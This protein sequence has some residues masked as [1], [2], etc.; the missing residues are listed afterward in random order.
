VSAT[1]A[2]L[3]QGSPALGYALFLAMVGTMAVA[4]LLGASVPLALKALGQD[5][6]LGSGV[7]VL[8]LTDSFGFFAFLGISTLLL[9]RLS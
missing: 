6:A 5:P 9:E 1:L 7:I 8:T 3:W 4:G 2:W